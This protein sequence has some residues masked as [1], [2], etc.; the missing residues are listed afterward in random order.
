MIRK[1]PVVWQLFT[2]HALGHSLLKY[3]D[4]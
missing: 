2:V 1:L 4:V 3:W